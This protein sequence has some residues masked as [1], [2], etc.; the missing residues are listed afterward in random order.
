VTRLVSSF[1]RVALSLTLFPLV[2]AILSFEPIHARSPWSASALALTPYALAFSLLAALAGRNPHR[3]PSPRPWLVA[4]VLSALA[5]G[6][7]VVA[8]GPGGIR[9]EISRGGDVIAELPSGPV[10][11]IGQ[12]LP[13]G[14][15]RR[16][17]L[18]WSGVL[19]AP[20]SG[21]YR[22][23]VEGRGD[24]SVRIAGQ[25]V[26]VARG[27]RLHAASAILLGRGEHPIEVIQ[28]RES[29]A[30]L[31]LHRI[32]GHRLRLGWVLP[33][34]DG[35][36]GARSEVI[37]PRFLGPA[38][39]DWMWVATDV[40]AMT[41]AALLALLAWILPWDAVRQ[42]PAPTPISRREVLLS[43]LA[44]AA[45]LVLM[46]WPLA[47]DL[48]GTGVVDQ[49]DGRLNVWI[50]GWVA[51]ALGHQPMALFDAPIFHPVLNTLALSENLLIPALIAAPASLL[52]EPVLGY[53][54]VLLVSLIASGLG[55]QF[56]VR[57]ATGD[58][59]AALVAGMM[60]AAGVHRW[61]RLAHLHAHVT[62]FMPF[63]LLALDRFWERRTLRRALAIGALVALQALSSIYL[64]AITATTLGAI[65]CVSA[66]A[67]LRFRDML[68][69]GAAGT[70]AAVLV[71]PVTFQYL[72]SRDAHATEWTLADVTP[73]ATT[74][75]SYIASGSRL[76]GGLTG[77]HLDPE[78]HRAPRFPGIV[79]LVLGIA[80][81]AVAPQ[82]YRVA[83][84]TASV[85][86]I[87]ISLGPETALYRFLHEHVIFFRGIRALA[88]FAIVPA[89]ALAVLAGCALAGR[90]RL[91]L[92]ALPL[93]LFE[94]C[95]A[96]L[97]FG[98][99]ERPGELARWLAGGSGGVAYLP[100]GMRDTEVMLDALAHHRPLLNG[101]SGLTPRH[102]EWA[103]ELLDGGP[104]PASEEA[105][106]F[107]RAVGVEHIVSA[108][109]LPLERAAQFGAESV[110][111]VTPGAPATV[112]QAGTARVALWSS[113]AVLLDLGTSTSVTHVTFEIGAWPWRAQPVIALSDD[114]VEWRTIAGRARLGDAVLA[115]AQ[116]PLRA[117][118]EITFPSQLARFVRLRD[119][120]IRP[121]PITA[122]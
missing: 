118:G 3:S 82:R 64:G 24:V 52:G 7:V 86:A 76:Y 56:L 18:R 103:H 43:S 16:F 70:L 10:D 78:R 42:L 23:W 105:Q 98:T 73:H 15:G 88:R 92:L 17:E 113:D 57:R 6:A 29:R 79:T 35:S 28:R 19:R 62:L 13:R 38:R 90:R 31:R 120:P 50:L 83:A 11:V 12:D 119:L 89:L 14:R 85:V 58:R 110:Y 94:S 102:Y 45:V 40:L 111:L 87:T 108:R 122:D 49:T 1:A 27:A 61:T 4:G 59:V 96:P 112:P 37:P 104:G 21:Q 67:G 63:A 106:R 8:R 109:A 5:L 117:R 75:E 74:L 25:A 39:P 84:L 71:A 44:Y 72:E 9:G 101:Y 34:A 99:Y 32:R 41:L 107:L 114:G 2:L 46:S 100:L 115:L 55:T 33:R 53:N 54:I 65:V 81:L 60:F 66:L 30:E 48:A 47:R 51:H 20:R 22:V 26:I 97:R 68:M 80:G 121:G 116:D 93:F 77:R 36:S 95:N 91:A 69:L